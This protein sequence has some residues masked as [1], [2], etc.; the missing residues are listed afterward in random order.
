M[1]P[2]FRPA[3][4]SEG[5]H[6][7]A[8]TRRFRY[9]VQ[10]PAHTLRT[11]WIPQDLLCPACTAD[12]GLLLVL[13]EHDGVNLVQV[14]CPAGHQWT[15]PRVDPNHFAAY[16]RLHGWAQPDLD[17]S[18]VLDAGF[19]EEPEPPIN[20]GKELKEGW[21]YALRQGRNAVKRRVKK[22]VRAQRRAAGKAARNAAYAPVAG[23]LRAA[24]FWQAGP[25][26][27]ERPK[28]KAKPYPDIPSVAKYRKA[29]GMAAPKRGPKCLVCEDTGRIPGTSITCT[30]C[31]GPAAAA[32]AAAEKRAERARAGKGPQ[33][34]D[35]TARGP[36]E[37][38]TT[39]SAGNG[40][41]QQVIVTG[42]GRGRQVTINGQKVAPQPMDRE[43]AARVDR[44]I[45]R[46]MRE[47]RQA[48]KESGGTSGST[49]NVHGKNNSIITNTTSAGHATDD[50]R[51]RKPATE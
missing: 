22:T 31:A 51:R 17:W 39:G 7:I 2:V 1:N 16:S 15:D 14:T 46:S 45:A 20:Y 50:G 4:P 29:Y 44:D 35:K 13:D 9:L 21:G 26:A 3:N 43:T 10:D 8:T 11:V 34:K 23:V 38:R 28:P 36:R 6:R 48:V 33:P 24:W 25:A 12:V 49:V 41:N 40:D 19:G 47:V 30:E 27:P 42:S 37:S 18:W 5:Y 32:M